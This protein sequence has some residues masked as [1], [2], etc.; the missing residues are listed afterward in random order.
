MK[1]FTPPPRVGVGMTYLASSP[2]LMQA[3]RGLVD[4]FE[5]SPDTLCQEQGRGPTRRLVPLPELWDRALRDTAA[6]P[7]IVHGLGLSIGSAHGWDTAYLGLLDELHARRPFLWHSEHLGFITAQQPNGELLHPGILLPMP[8]TEESLQLLV[9]RA[10]EMGQRYGVP[11]LL[12]NLT[13]YLPELPSEGGRDEVAFLNELS[14]R[15]GCGLLFD[16]YNFHCNALNL[17]F[18]AR[19]A[20]RRVN[21]ERVIHVHVAGGRTHDGFL[22]DVHS[23][24]VPEPVWELLE[25]L[26]P[27]APN[28]AGVSYELLEEAKLGPAD[29]AGQLERVRAVWDKH[30][31]RPQE[32]ANRGTA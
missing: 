5:L 10:A 17:G 13:Y 12:E 27:R 18:D 30:H 29:V 20:L 14:E 26:V 23:D 1:E 22:M 19:E 4:F 28:L 8:F 6:Y 16:L 32:A 2:A 11:F 3:A 9:P 15:S 7:L 31:P 21:L 25:W 24:V